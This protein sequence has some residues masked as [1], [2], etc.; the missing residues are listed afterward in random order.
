MIIVLFAP[1]ILSPLSEEGRYSMLVLVFITTF[2]MPFFLISLAIFLRK[3]NVAYEDLTM[4][5]KKGRS[6]PFLFTGGYYAG[7]AWMV[8]NNLKLTPFVGVV[9]SCIAGMVLVLALISMFWKISAHATGLGGLL[10]L[11]VVTGMIFPG[12][13]LFWP[14]IVAV[15]VAGLV[16]SA[17]LYLKAHS[18]VQVL[19][20]A[21][22]GLLTGVPV[23]FLLV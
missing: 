9:I 1:V 13:E 11:L 12:N 19:A 17:R 4:K 5:D 22:L 14:V 6:I 8:L 7:L 10:S 21:A 15:L 20:G 23:Y 2:L 18:A 3:K 16:L